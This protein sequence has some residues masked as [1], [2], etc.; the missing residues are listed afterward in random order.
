M[1]LNFLFLTKLLVCVFLVC[2]I[3]FFAGCGDDDDEKIDGGKTGEVAGVYEGDYKGAKATA[4]FR[5]NGS[6][7]IVTDFGGGDKITENFTWRVSG[8]FDGNPVLKI[9]FE[10]ED[11]EEMDEF[12]FDGKDTIEFGVMTLTR[13]K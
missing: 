2:G 1:K 7:T 6:G 5:Q 8:Y 9:K 12:K 3:M 4:T 10:G 13:K 11:E